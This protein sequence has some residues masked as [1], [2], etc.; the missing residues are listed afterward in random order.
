MRELLDHL[1]EQYGSPTAYLRA[2]GL[3]D[4]EIVEALRRALVADDT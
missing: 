1:T 2:H 3:G 4:D